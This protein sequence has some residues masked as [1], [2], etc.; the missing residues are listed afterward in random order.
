MRKQG[1]RFCRRWTLLTLAAT[2][3][4][5]VVWGLSVRGQQ[6]GLAGCKPPALFWFRASSYTVTGT[7]LGRTMGHLCNGCVVADL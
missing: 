4:P 6:S 2:N 5:F 1:C 3:P 7:M